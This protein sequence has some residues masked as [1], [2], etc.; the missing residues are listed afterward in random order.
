M[1]LRKRLPLFKVKCS[2]WIN[3]KGQTIVEFVLLLAVVSTISYAF[4]ASINTFMGKYWTHSVNLIINDGDPAR[5][6]PPSYLKKV[7]LD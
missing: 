4:V 5:S 2:Q 1:K 6:N 7:E 3:Q